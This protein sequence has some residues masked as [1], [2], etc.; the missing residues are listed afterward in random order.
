MAEAN[1][2][3]SEEK[4]KQHLEQ[5]LELLN[6]Q[7]LEEAVVQ[8]QAMP[9]HQ[10]VETLLHKQQQAALK[11]KLDQLHSADIAYILEALP[12]EQRLLVWNLVKS[13]LD[14]QIL[15]DVS[16]A[17]RET[18]ISDMDRHE[19]LS[20]TEQLDTDEIAD[21]A[22]VLPEEVMQ[23]L[24]ESLNHQNRARL[25]SV[26]GHEEDTVASLMDFGMV[27]IREDITL[28]VVLRYLRRRGELPEHTDKLF[29]VDKQNLL[30][31]VLPL[32]RLLVNSPDAPVAD[33]MSRDVVSFQLDADAEDAARAFERYD[34]L[35]APVV[36]RENRLQGRIGVDAI[37]DHI[38]E[39]S[40]ED[41]LAQA[42]L[43]EEEDLFS[44]VWKSAKN[45]WFWLAV[46]LV[47]A[48]LST[49]VIGLFE[50]T[51]AHIVALASLMPIVAGIGGNTGTQTSTL[52]V[53]SL[54]LDLITPANAGRLI[55]KELSIG[56]LNGAVWGTVIGLFAWG[57]YGDERLALV[58]ASAMMLNLL[59]A[60]MVGLAVP[61][62][63]HKLHLDPAMGTSVLLTAITDG[64]G[65][66]IFLGLATVFLL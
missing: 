63:R 49:R 13:E 16:D 33:I 6:K 65:F 24:L 4:L 17:V 29:V 27:T 30:R 8:Q 41:M 51:I 36:D 40:K 44:S 26:L 50:N 48:F 34:L 52:I 14:G 3:Q 25:E 23:E 64:M 5:V 61:L 21:L 45:R 37:L 35:S 59:L 32:Q 42:G 53:R 10:L 11:H 9:R 46:N 47:T 22:P 39:K 2:T 55:A 19:L 20:A 31:G 57:L 12:L 58:M 60:A 56:F 38:R 15:L 1:N 18:L 28:G 66:F 54:A 62:M 43:L 7:R